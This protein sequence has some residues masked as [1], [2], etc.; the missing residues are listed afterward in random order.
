[1]DLTLDL[2]LV[3]TKY[4]PSSFLSNCKFMST[5]SSASFSESSWKTMLK[6]ALALGSSWVTG[7]GGGFTEGVTPC[8]MERLLIF[9]KS[10]AF[11]MRE[12]RSIGLEES[13]LLEIDLI[14]LED[15]PELEPFTD[16]AASKS[17]AKVDCLFFAVINECLTV[18]LEDLEDLSSS[19]SKAPAAAKELALLIRLDLPSNSISHRAAKSADA[20]FPY[21]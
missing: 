18:F 11:K 20:R 3:S 12:I 8:E 5:V 21:S 17:E 16:A 1:M 19:A 2:R 15:S 7:L 9:S 10:L 14:D 6:R 13:L 4:K